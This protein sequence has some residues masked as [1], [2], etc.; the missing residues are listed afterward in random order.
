MTTMNRNNTSFP[1]FT[2]EMLKNKK[3]DPQ[4]DELYHQFIV[5]QYYENNPTQRGLLCFHEMGRGKTRLA[6]NIIKNFKD[7][8][9]IVV[10]APKKVFGKFVSEMLAVNLKADINFISLK[11]NNLSDQ[12]DKLQ[13]TG[14]IDLL[15]NNTLDNSFLIIDEAHNFFNAII[16]GSKN[17]IYL[18][19]SIM[20][21]K[22]IKLL[23]LTGTPII[24]TP[25]EL[26]P[27]YNMLS[28]LFACCCC[29]I[30]SP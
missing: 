11:A 9:K 27:C 4:H 15:V 1:L 18:Y 22:N 19:D 13:V 29:K 7:K 21:A 14:E 23:F 6:V 26:A 8:V 25:F 12:I 24:N 5:R 28:G 10:I 2:Y 17:A 3:F 20:A 30:Q 16:N